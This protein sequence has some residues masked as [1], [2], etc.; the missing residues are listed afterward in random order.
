[1]NIHA[2]YRA[3]G[4]RFRRKRM[5]DFVRAFGI[6]AQ[7]RILD[8]GGTLYNW[9]LIDVPPQLTI[10]N[11]SPPP[12]HL[13]DNV[14]WIV[15]DACELP[16]SDNSFDVVYSNS[17]IEHLFTR[18]AQQRMA[19]EV[20][21][22][23]P[24]YYVQTPNSRFPMEPHYLTPF[25]HWFPVPLRKR[26]IRN[27]TLWGWITRPSREACARRVEE[28]QLLNEQELRNLFPDATILRERFAGMTK[29][30]IVVKGASG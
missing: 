9:S 30:L 2:I 13:P 3:V 28:I 7:T 18:E 21:R 16:F 12:A 4:K 20:Q 8:I 15:A 14:S 6:T 17:V 19:R 10:V 1:M 27:F 23:A 26:M 22:L 24:K 11:L 5:G 25:I 29:S